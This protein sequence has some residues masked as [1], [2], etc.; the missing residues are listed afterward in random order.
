MNRSESIENPIWVIYL[1]GKSLKSFRRPTY[2]SKLHIFKGFLT[3]RVKIIKQWK[4]IHSRICE[5]PL[6]VVA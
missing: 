4:P 6:T 3:F 2:L 5:K 1:H